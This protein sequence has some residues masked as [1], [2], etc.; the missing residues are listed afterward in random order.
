[1]SSANRKNVNNYA[2][3]SFPITQYLNSESTIRVISDENLDILQ[4]IKQENVKDFG[5]PCYEGEVLKRHM[6]YL[7]RMK[8]SR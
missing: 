2:F 7:K 8:R 3:L 5:K 1:M 4:E 6:N